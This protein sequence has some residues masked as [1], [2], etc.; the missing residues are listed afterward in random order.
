M[1]LLLCEAGANTA[2]QDVSGETAL[3]KAQ[4]RN[5]TEIV[6]LLGRQGPSLSRLELTGRQTPA[7]SSRPHIPATDMPRRLTMPSKTA[8]ASARAL[9]NPPKHSESGQVHRHDSR[10]G[11]CCEH[12]QT[13]QKMT[14]FCFCFVFCF[15]CLV[16]SK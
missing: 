10:L 7:M 5:N 1:V 8:P 12:G 9:S 13:K 4:K 16:D 14:H 3:D 2:H 15:V 6:V 11:Q